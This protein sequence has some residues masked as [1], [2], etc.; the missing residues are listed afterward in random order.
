[1]AVG[2]GDN[3][4]KCWF[5]AT[6]D[7]KSISMGKRYAVD[8]DGVRGGEEEV[9]VPFDEGVHL[10]TTGWGREEA[11]AIGFERWGSLL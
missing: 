11:K 3:G 1:M 5:I 8:G 7:L 4:G 2:E 10:Q 6:G 9:G